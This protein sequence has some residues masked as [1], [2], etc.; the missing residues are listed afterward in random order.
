MLRKDRLALTYVT[1]SATCKME[2]EWPV[3]PHLITVMYSE[4]RSRVKHDMNLA[5][6]NK[7]I[8]VP[9][10]LSRIRRENGF[11]ASTSIVRSR[12]SLKSVAVSVSFFPRRMSVKKSCRTKTIHDT[13]AVN[14]GMD[15]VLRIILLFL[16]IHRN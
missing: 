13:A 6:L 15:R 4:V 1:E 16:T 10:L 11:E 14:V 9:P 5:N 3:V 12:R 8:V 7:R 2:C